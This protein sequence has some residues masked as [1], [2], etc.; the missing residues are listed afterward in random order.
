MCWLTPAIVTFTLQKCNWEPVG[1]LTRDNGA[2]VDFTEANFSLNI[3][4]LINHEYF[5]DT[6]THLS[7]ERIPERVVHAKGAGA[8]GFFEVTHDISDI[9]K[10]ELFDGVGKTTPIAI[11]FSAVAADRG[12]NDLVSDARGFAVKFYTKAG[13]FDIVGLNTPVFVLK[14]PLGFPNFV[15]VNGRNPATNL[16]DNNMMWEFITYYPESLFLFLY[17]FSGFGTPYSYRYMPGFS[18][19]TYQVENSIGDTHFIRFHIIPDLG[20]KNLSPEE[21]FKIGAV[22][23]DF[24]TRDLYDAIGEGNFPSWSVSIQVLSQ[25]DVEHAD[26]DVFDTTRLLPEDKY[27]LRPLGRIVLD[28]NPVNYFAE[29]EQIA[30]CPSNLVPGILGAPDKLFE[31][32][33]L[34]YRD[35]QYYR[36]GANFKKIPVNC[37][38]RSKVF[39]Y[40][41]DGRPTFDSNGKDAPN[42]YPN[43]FFGP[44]P[45]VTCSN[46]RLL[47]IKQ[48]PAYNF[49]Q[50][51]QLINDMSEEQRNNLV[52][53]ILQSLGTVTRLVQERVI[54]LISSV[55]PKIGEKIAVQIYL[56]RTLI[57]KLH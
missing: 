19:H 11:R 37:P 21:S 14:E 5:M 25:Y 4:S 38:Y 3:S 9:C 44:V 26:F 8:F 28:R 43:S 41:R 6:I 17:I 20:V 23:G 46:T 1:I 32:R 48:D 18:I 12:R 13:N 39:T 10:A 51:A 56:N 42:Y 57:D 29:I 55:N 22:D 49:D 54:Q 34:S 16:F 31:S 33:R 15:H 7:R 36:L 30:F 24:Y 45:R 2:P 35:T 40:E 53:N 47:E 52:T 50:A 27:P